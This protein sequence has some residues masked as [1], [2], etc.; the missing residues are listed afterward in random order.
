MKR[1]DRQTRV[2]TI[3]AWFSLRSATSTRKHN[4]VH[5]SEC[6]I[7]E[8]AYEKVYYY[9]EKK[10]QYSAKPLE[11]MNPTPATKQIPLCYSRELWHVFS[12]Y[13]FL[14]GLMFL[15]IFCCCSL[16][17]L[18]HFKSHFQI[19]FICL[20]ISYIWIYLIDIILINHVKYNID[21]I[22]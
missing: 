10:Q 2:H 7:H 1:W 6:Y 8:K 22:I 16:D 21:I 11:Y 3:I 4:V 17:F 12:W 9:I 18:T 15:C 5:L 13:S 20:N 19:M 14:F